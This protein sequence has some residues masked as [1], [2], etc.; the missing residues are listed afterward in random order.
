M[1][2]EVKNTSG[3]TLTRVQGEWD[4]LLEF[5]YANGEQEVFAWILPKLQQS[6]PGML[7]SH[8][9]WSPSLKKF[10]SYSEETEKNIIF[11]APKMTNFSVKCCYRVMKL[12]E[13][14]YLLFTSDSNT[15]IANSY[16]LLHADMV[17]AAVIPEACLLVCLDITLPAP[18]RGVVLFSS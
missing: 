1:T 12:I 9:R 5:T 18:F 4:S 16:V 7:G 15:F 13:I 17:L 3:A 2:A 8:P 14:S 11:S 6:S 10:A